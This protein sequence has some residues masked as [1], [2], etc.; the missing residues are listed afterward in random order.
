MY[1]T[2]III[3]ICAS[4]D[5]GNLLFVY[6]AICTPYLYTVNK[7]PLGHTFFILWFTDPPTLFFD[8]M[9]KK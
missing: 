7:L 4:P 2:S 8:E 5:Q 1:L 6:C 9:E 3:H